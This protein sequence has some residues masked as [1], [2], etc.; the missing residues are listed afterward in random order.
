MM[1]DRL[2][3]STGHLP[4]SHTCWTDIF[5]RLIL[6]FL[7]CLLTPPLGCTFQLGASLLPSL[8]RLPDQMSTSRFPQTIFSVEALPS[9]HHSHARLPAIGQT[10]D[11]LRTR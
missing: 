1:R 6:W 4:T 10:T 9:R 11:P 8:G 2:A 3:S 5:C 7:R